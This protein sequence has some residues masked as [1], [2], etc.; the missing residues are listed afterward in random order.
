[1]NEAHQ[2]GAVLV[3]AVFDAF[4]HIYKRRTADL[5]RLATGGSGVPPTG[6]ISTDLISRLSH[7][8]SKVAGH[9]LNICI[10][11]LDYCPP[12]D[13]YF[14]EYLRALITADMDLMPEDEHGYRVA[15]IEAF[16]RRGIYPRDVR[17]LSE[18][19]LRWTRPA[20]D[21]IFNP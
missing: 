12:V 16:R 3:A 7:E 13:L 18:D 9:I 6:E 17:T 20:E 15:F 19:S 14:G 11:A 2:L 21:P 4:L 10:R 8:A 5:L 1:A